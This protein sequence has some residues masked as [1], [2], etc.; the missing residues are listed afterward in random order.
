MAT[1]KVTYIQHGQTFTE[2]PRLVITAGGK[3]K[4]AFVSDNTVLASV[5]CEDP[6]ADLWSAA[7]IGALAMGQRAERNRAAI[8]Q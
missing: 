1:F 2:R 3:Y 6:D 7:R 4:A 8:S 5:P